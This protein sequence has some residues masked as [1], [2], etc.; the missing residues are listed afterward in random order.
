MLNREDCHTPLITAPSFPSY[1]EADSANQELQREVKSTTSS[2]ENNGLHRTTHVETVLHLLKGYL[3][4]GFLSLPYAMS[5]LG[6]T[7]GCLSIFALSYWTSSN[8]YTVVSIKRHM[9]RTTANVLPPQNDDANSDSMSET[10]SNITYP[11]VGNWAYGN[12]FRS[13]VSACIITLQMAVCTVFV[14]FIGENLLAVVQ[15]FGIASM[16]HASVMTVALPVIFCLSLVPGLKLLA[17]ITAAGTVLLMV[18]LAAL[19]KIVYD[20]WPDRPESPPDLQ[21]SRVPLALCMILY[22]YEGINLILPVQAA[23]KTPADFDVVFWLAMGIVA[24][25]LATVAVV[26]VLAFGDVTNGSVTA[27]LLENADDDSDNNAT[28]RWIMLA[29]AAVSV[30]VLLTYPLTMY[31]AVELLG[32]VVQRN[33]FLSKWFGGSQSYRYDDDDSLEDF[34]PLPPLPEHDAV[35]MDQ[36]TEHLYDDI[37]TPAKELEEEMKDGEVASALSSSIAVVPS[38]GCC[39]ARSSLPGDSPQLRAALVMITYLVA[40]SVPNVQALISLVGALAGSSAALLIPPML[41]IAWIQQLEHMATSQT[42]STRTPPPSPHILRQQKKQQKRRKSA[43]SSLTASPYWKTK[44]KC[45]LSF[46]MGLIFLGIG[47]SASVWDIVLI[48]RGIPS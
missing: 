21:P 18:S 19:S 40:V 44:I 13:Y 36:H 10:S 48:Y 38:T 3:G 1:T 30:S 6:I 15:Y 43:L 16:T 17:P 8:C 5:Q 47:T 23:M 39:P 31:P 41:E 32:P 26:C 45:Y 33:A 42:S 14:S 35:A 2:K 7:G 4:A 46:G 27:F 37:L 22:S 12:Y 25:V 9:E 24:L 34:E 28:T 11:D 20:E 29:N